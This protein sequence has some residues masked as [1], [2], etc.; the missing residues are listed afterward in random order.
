MTEQNKPRSLPLL[1]LDFS[2]GR[3]TLYNKSNK[4]LDCLAE[5]EEIIHFSSMHPRFIG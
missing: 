2:R 1:V 4:W 3:Q 5:G